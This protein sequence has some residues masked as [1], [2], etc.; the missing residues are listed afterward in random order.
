MIPVLL[1]L[2]VVATGWAC[3]LWAEVLSKRQCI[4]GLYDTVQLF[5]RKDGKVS[6]LLVSLESQ[7]REE[8]D[9]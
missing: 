6:V 2:L 5:R 4:N 9:R 8:L 3:I 1:I 7:L